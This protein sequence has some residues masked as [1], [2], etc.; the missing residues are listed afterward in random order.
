MVLPSEFKTIEQD[1]EILVVPTRGV[2]NSTWY[3]WNSRWLRSMHLS[4][5]G[6]IISCGWPKFMNL[7]EGVGEYKVTEKDILD[8]AGK[9]LIATLKIDGS[10]LVRF[11]HNGK[12]RFRTR[13]SLGVFVDNAHEVKQFCEENPRL[14]DPKLLPG[15]SVLFEWVSPDNQIVIKYKQPHLF[16]TGAVVYDRN[17]PWHDARLRLLSMKELKQIQEDLEVELVHHYELHSKSEVADLIQDLQTNRE[18]EGFALRFDNE[19]QLVKVKG[20]HYFILHALRSN[21]TTNKLI[22]LWIC[23]NRPK[24]AEYAQEF[25]SIYDYECWTWAMPAVSSM[26]D[27]VREANGIVAHVKAF[28]DGNS[29]LPRKE[30][31]LLSQKRFNQLRLALCFTFYDHREV[32]NKTWSKLVIQHC[33]QFEMQCVD[34]A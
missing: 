10:L 5:D 20:E 19:Q 34:D 29:Y 9:D 31:A 15:L 14:L 25:I 7:N 33:K 26:F 3:D 8:R 27:G 17:R 18:I 30:F 11:V 22:E 1:G 21:L 16:L 2:G 28:V 12:V 24:Y 23:W 13:G 4:E 32:E 6:T